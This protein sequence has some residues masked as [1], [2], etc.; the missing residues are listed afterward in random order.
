MTPGGSKRTQWVDPSISC[1]HTRSEWLLRGI[2]FCAALCR[3]EPYGRSWRIASYG[4]FSGS[5]RP[6]LVS[7]CVFECLGD[8]VAFE[9]GIAAGTLDGR[10][11]V[12]GFFFAH[13]YCRG[14]CVRRGSP[15]VHDPGGQIIQ[16]NGGGGT[17]CKGRFDRVGKLADVAGPKV[18]IC[19]AAIASV[20]TPT[21]VSR[22]RCAR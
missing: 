12:I 15:G 16:R 19:N 2:V 7:A 22:P 3:P 14:D 17:E 8:N 18:Q 6:H 4:R 10:G 5:G 21:T 1:D 11:L 13:N 9:F 20:A